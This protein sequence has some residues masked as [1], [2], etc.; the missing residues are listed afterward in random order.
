MIQAK[1]DARDIYANAGNKNNIKINE[2]DIEV[3]RVNN[4]GFIYDEKG[5]AFNF[6]YKLLFSV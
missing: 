6:V 2:E 1:D 4:M 3:I 5:N